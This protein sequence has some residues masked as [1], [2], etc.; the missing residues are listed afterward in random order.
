M[1]HSA[2][3]EP[4][5]TPYE[6]VGGEDAIRKLADRFYDLMDE[7]PS[8]AALR[9]LH[10]DDLAPMRTR[11]FEF[12]S[13]WLGGPKLYTKCV[14]SAHARFAIGKAERDQWL[15]CMDRAM[16]DTAFPR[17]I[18]ALVSPVFAR[19]SDAMVMA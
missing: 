10:A 2:K 12:L 9:T 1:N 13:G 14:M 4:H 16:A 17:E 19:M 3:A 8:Y 7:D 15:A 5:I 6:F 11:L 18:R